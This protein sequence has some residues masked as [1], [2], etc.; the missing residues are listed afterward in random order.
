M[1]QAVQQ[2]QIHGHARTIR[3]LMSS[4]RYGLEYYQREYGWERTQVEE[5]F[6][7]LNSAFSNQREEGHT[8]RSV[9]QYRPYFLG[10]II[11]S[12]REGVAYV[13]DGQQRLTTLS[14]LMINLLHRLPEQ[15]E[16]R[17]EVQRCVF[18]TQYGE[19]SFTLDVPEREPCMQA[20]LDGAPF[21]PAEK[22]ESVRNLWARY[23]DLESLA[24]IDDDDLPLFVEWLLGKVVLVEITTS[25]SNMAYRSSRP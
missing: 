4:Q 7:D 8:R 25:E 2:P 12:T 24:E 18:S 10:P 19:N 21:D 23:Q 14:L 1:P 11:T 20:L 13:I 9:A 5:L 6:E 15:N 17:A 22:S 16:L 3:E